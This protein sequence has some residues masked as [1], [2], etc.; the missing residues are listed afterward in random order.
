MLGKNR[1]TTMII[2]D[3][4]YISNEMKDYMNYSQNAV[5]NN[6]MALNENQGQ[7]FNVV[8]KNEF[9]KLYQNGE[10]LYTV[11]ENS[12]DWI[13]QN[14]PDE[15]LINCINIMKDKVKFRGLLKEMYPDFFYKEIAA[16][17]L[18]NLDFSE[19]SLPLIIKPSVGF[20]S[21]GVYTV[22]NEDDWN[23][24]IND[25]FSSM[26]EWKK[27]FPKNVVSNSV[28]ILEQYIKGDEYAI[29]AYYDE[30]GQA[31]I[32]NIMKHDFSS[33]SD[34]SDRLYYTGKEIIE[35]HLM[36]FTVFLN[37]ANKHINARDFPLHAEVRIDDGRIMPIEFNPMRFAGWCCTDLV[38]F[39]FG[40]KTYDYYFKNTK[41]DWATLLQGKENK[42]YSLIVLDKPEN[43]KAIDVFNYEKVCDRFNK[44]IN[45]RRLDYQKQPISGF[46]F[47]ETELNN[48]EELDFVIKSDFKEFISSKDEMV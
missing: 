5:L 31:V 38:Y 44:V 18:K 19:L 39:A 29:D 40:F 36:D 48:R 12:I 7:H 32:L 14:I 43:L 22:T 45:L 16:S 8:E 11:S 15:K 1:G 23:F 21:V 33:I 2:L 35:D 4:P 42:L 13:Y 28:F 10:R 9:I 47:T 26:Q 41:P 34:V 27:S 24:A 30:N 46:L 6:E 37:D 25:I 20:F 3:K 17:D